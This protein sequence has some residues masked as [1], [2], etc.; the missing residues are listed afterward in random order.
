MATEVSAHKA[1]DGHPLAGTPLP[2]FSRYTFSGSS[3]FDVLAQDVG[4][5]PGGDSNGLAF[6]SPPVALVG[7]VVQHISE[8]DAR[9]VVVVPAVSGTMVSFAEQSRAQVHPHCLHRW[10]RG[11]CIPASPAGG[12]AVVCFS[13]VGN[14]CG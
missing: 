11:V 8:C 5:L 2:F 3:G 1:P 4:R 10:G 9:A 12:A 14:A 13:K 6:N 7:A